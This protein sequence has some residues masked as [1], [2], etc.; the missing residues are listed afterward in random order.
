MT[1]YYMVISCL[2]REFDHYIWY[3]FLVVK[4]LIDRH[5]CTRRVQKNQARK[6]Q[7]T[8]AFPVVSSY[9]IKLTVNNKIKRKKKDI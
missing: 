7:R 8:I 3:Y 1:T 4:S 5:L 6:P 2:Y 9:S